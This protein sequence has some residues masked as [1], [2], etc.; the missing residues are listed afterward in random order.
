MGGEAYTAKSTLE[1]SAENDDN[2]DNYDSEN[3]KAIV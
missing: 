3:D 2:D 1:L